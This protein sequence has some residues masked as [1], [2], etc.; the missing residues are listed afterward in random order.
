MPISFPCHFFAAFSPLL[1]LFSALFLLPYYRVFFASFFIRFLYSFI[2][3]LFSV[4]CIVSVVLDCLCAVFTRNFHTKPKKSNYRRTHIH[5]FFSST[6]SPRQ[7]EREKS[8]N[9]PQS[10]KMCAFARTKSSD[11]RGKWLTSRETVI[12]FKTLKREKNQ[13]WN[14][15]T[16]KKRRINEWIKCKE[17]PNGIGEK[18][19]WL[20][21]IIKWI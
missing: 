7:I 20:G 3:I 17:T 4:L 9:N 12:N 19:V 16:T 13:H 2:Y 10:W 15:E 11:G 6:H 1:L 14:S 21:S 5:L 18:L 8:N